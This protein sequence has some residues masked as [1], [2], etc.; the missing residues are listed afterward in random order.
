MLMLETSFPKSGFHLKARILSSE[1]HMSA[2]FLEVTAHSMHF[3]ENAK[4]PSLNNQ[5]WSVSCSFKHKRKKQRWSSQHNHKSAPGQTAAHCRG[6]RTSSYFPFHHTDRERDG[7]K[8]CSNEINHFSCAIKDVLS[9]DFPGG[10][11][12]KTLRPQCR[13]AR[14]DPWSGK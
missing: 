5:S 9:R 6:R 2:V 13:G 4:S 11:V 10:P 1:I 3:W 8:V 7:L 14:F 12:G